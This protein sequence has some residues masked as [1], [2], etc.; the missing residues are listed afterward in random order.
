MIKKKLRKWYPTKEKENQAVLIEKLLEASNHIHRS[1][2]TNPYANW[3]IVGSDVAGQLNN[4][5]N[6]HNNHFCGTTYTTTTTNTYVPI[7]MSTAST[8]TILS[9][10]TTIW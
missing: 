7:H 10:T 4:V 3:V 9:G 5:Y 2:M 6:G 1:T 8:M